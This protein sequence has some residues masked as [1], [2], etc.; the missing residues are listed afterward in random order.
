MTGRALS[1]DKL[2]SEKFE[3]LCFVVAKRLFGARG[4]FVSVDDH[5]G[6]DG[7]EFYLALPDGTEWGWQSKF[8]TDGRLSDSRRRACLESLERSRE[9]HHALKRWFLCLTMDLT[10]DERAWFDDTLTARAG[11]VEVEL[12][13]YREFVEMLSRED[14]AGIRNAFLGELELSPAWFLRIVTRVLASVGSKFVSELHVDPHGT[15]RLDALLQNQNWRDA[16]AA[17]EKDL[18][19]IER[20]LE[21]ELRPKEHGGATGKA[22][23]ALDSVRSVIAGLRTAVND[24]RGC[25]DPAA[26]A[27]HSAALL[28]ALRSDAVR[29]LPA[30]HW[31]DPLAAFDR[32][33]ADP[34]GDLEA[35]LIDAT[36]RVLH[37]H[38][39]A[40]TGKTHI[41]C[42]IA[43]SRVQ[44][45]EP[46]ILLLGGSFH[47]S[48]SLPAQVLEQLDAPAS[49]SWQGF[50]ASLD[51]YAA[52]RDAVAAIIIDGLNEP[53]GAS[54]WSS[55]LPQLLADLAPHPRVRLIT[56]C[57]S[58]YLPVVGLEGSDDLADLPVTL[59]DVRRLTDVY[60]RHYRIKADMS[61]QAFERFR[62]P[63]Y[64]RMFCEAQNRARSEWKEVLIG[65]ETVFE[66]FAEYLRTVNDLVCRR[67][68]RMSVDLVRPAL[69][70]VA[71]EMWRSGRAEV[72]WAQ[73]PE[74]VDRV[75]FD[76]LS[77]QS[78]LTR[79]LLDEDLLLRRE[80]AGRGEMVAFS[81]DLFAGW[82]IAEHLLESAAPLADLLAS[83]ETSERLLGEPALRL[84]PDVLRAL[85]T[86]LPTRTG[87]HLFEFSS[88]ERL[89]EYALAACFEMRPEQV[90]ERAAGYVEAAC[91]H[92]ER[93]T[94][95][96][97]LAHGVALSSRHP[98]NSSFFD[99]LLRR[100]L[101]L[102]RDLL[103]SEPAR[104]R[105]EDLSAVI[106]VATTAARTGEPPAYAT[107]AVMALMA[108]YAMWLQC[109]V[110]RRI[111]DTAARALHWI[112][113]RDP[114]LVF[115]LIL[116]SLEINDPWVR[117]RMVAIGY[118]IALALHGDPARD[119]LR[120]RIL[121][122]YA[123]S[124]FLSL[125]APE[126]S[127]ATSNVLERDFASRTIRLARRYAPAFL[128]DEEYARA[129]PPFIA[130]DLP[131]DGAPDSVRNLV[132]TE[133]GSGLLINDKHPHY[134]S[135]TRVVAARVHALGWEA[136]SLA[137]ADTDIVESRRWEGEPAITYMEKYAR[138]ALWEAVGQARYGA[139]TGRW[140]TTIGSD[141]RLADID[142]SFPEHRPTMYQSP[143]KSAALIAA[144]TARARGSAVRALLTADEVDAAPDRWLLACGDV[145]EKEPLESIHTR[146]IFVDRAIATEFAQGLVKLG[147]H[148]EL[149]GEPT[150]TA[151]W[152]GEYGFPE[153]I[154]SADDHPVITTIMKS[155][156]EKAA[157]AGLPEPAT[158]RPV[159][160]WTVPARLTAYRS[161]LQRFDTGWASLPGLLRERL[162]ELLTGE[163]GDYNAF[164]P[165]PEL[166][167]YG[168]LRSSLPS[169]DMNTPDGRRA[170]RTI[171]NRG[172]D[173]DDDDGLAPR[174]AHLLYI[175]RDLLL[176]Y[177]TESAREAVYVVWAN[178]PSR[179]AVYVCTL[180]HQ[181]AIRIVSVAHHD[182]G[183][184][185]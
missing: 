92:P 146:C 86:I 153:W 148:P 98:L 179:I 171:V 87:R 170:T 53:L 161:H 85:A 104:L 64:L 13:G 1:F 105:V 159:I 74:I 88:D 69:V 68:D 18:R 54:W 116:G 76:R 103:W 154:P 17:A 70:R 47:A 175:R 25:T 130:I 156:A 138:I 65:D 9:K 117:H 137:A 84:Y 134:E 182:G 176:G 166:V 123:K 135:V 63:L 101:P 46:A 127:F 21:L 102:E 12:W 67:L 36:R 79:A 58:S 129:L 140:A 52:S 38:G 56:T 144:S 128:G 165:A 11:D 150:D 45:N 23:R 2:D 173:P 124:L 96:F 60:F 30:E 73:L 16:L 66:V 90:D 51:A 110:D 149:P 177:L 72:P 132:G 31:Q 168:D 172:A 5:G 48:R 75:P 27:A 142:C 19:G 164:V 111:R 43:S 24:L 125:F 180:N 8:Y 160:R 145:H 40:G 49:C 100:L 89:A 109:T 122:A 61:Q 112:G 78:S 29:G 183:T 121:P 113:R 59:P 10:P 167:R 181:G 178:R 147:T 80:Y 143:A 151:T 120:E 95:A 22:R 44:R 77:W 141:Y 115:N 81:Y 3:A 133:V 108:R 32:R 99:P 28:A 62:H 50:L 82:L 42:Q 55:Q 136:E 41:A 94:L 118:G 83:A 157:K 26:A 169:F 184:P 57:R 126:A 155:L 34:F 114:E 33:S 158:T 20:H 185:S 162:G 174:E 39:A 71:A 97:R 4:R 37:V 93:R 152:A 6:G 91:R 106:E 131:D 7:V 14:L 139:P 15:R 35:L 163:R 119:E 107:A